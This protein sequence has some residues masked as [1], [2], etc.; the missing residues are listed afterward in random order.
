MK[1]KRSAFSFLEIKYGGKKEKI[2]NFFYETEENSFVCCNF[3]DI[4]LV[5]NLIFLCT[6]ALLS[7]PCALIYYTLN[8]I[9]YVRCDLA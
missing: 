3:A 9:F 5:F 2:D 1:N 8:I 4:L 6:L 7:S